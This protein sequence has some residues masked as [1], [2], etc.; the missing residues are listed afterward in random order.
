[1]NFSNAGHAVTPKHSLQN[2][3]T[4]YLHMP[5]QASTVEDTFLKYEVYFLY[6]N[7]NK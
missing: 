2:S 3:V 6:I 1:M 4:D 7:N 5:L